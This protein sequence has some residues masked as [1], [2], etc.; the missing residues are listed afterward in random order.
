MRKSLFRKYFML[1]SIILIVS[2][3][4]L[5]G[6]IMVFADGFWR[7]EKGKL[8]GQNVHS[9]SALMSE[10]PSYAFMGQMLNLIGNV[11]DA[12]VFIADSTG[13]TIV[14]NHS[15]YDANCYHQQNTVP[16]AVMKKAGAGDFT[17]LGT[18]GGMF[19]NSTYIVGTPLFIDGKVVGGVFA[20]VPAADLWEYLGKI[21]RMFLVA[22]LVV[23]VLSFI[24]VYVIT[25]RMT[26]PLRIMAQAAR[27][28]AK[29]NFLTKIP[30]GSRDDEIGELSVA[31]NNMTMSL[32]SLE[33]M[34]RSFISN[35]SHELKTPMTT[36][37]GFID[38]IL[39]GTIEPDKEKQYLTVVSQE[40]KR[41]SRLVTSMLNLS[42]LEA[43]E[44][45]L[46]PIRFNLTEIML[47]TILSFEQKIE[48]KGISIEG[49]EDAC[50]LWIYA[51]PDLM[52]QVVYNLVENA[53]KFTPDGAYIRFLTAK[54]D[55]SCS[56]RITNSGDG[57]SKQELSRIFERFY[58]TDKS[59]GMDK[60]GIGLGLYIVQTIVGIHG[61]AI[62]ADSVEGEYTCVGF[63][64][65]L[66]EGKEDPKRIK[67]KKPEGDVSDTGNSAGPDQAN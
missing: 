40:V 47:R 10:S 56:V 6:I 18:M 57:L 49:L 16:A 58:K 59:R 31:F 64:L 33:Q 35:V 24:A 1:T 8:L 7:S 46:R 67:G 66:G 27:S 50:P 55:Q 48:A 29:G 39:D 28:M 62:Y 14:C 23:G 19:Q 63:T 42:R 20:T 3:T 2:F 11:V 4:I 52:H 51:D 32:A 37:A 26:R 21:L 41:L 61:G 15:L 22:V 30:E 44:M 36:I 13:A 17:E 12:D 5:G 65:P 53:I 34:R 60:T 9:V 43:G 45:E 38:G 54:D 25:A